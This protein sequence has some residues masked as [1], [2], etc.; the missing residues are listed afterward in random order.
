MHVLL[1]EDEKKTISFLYKGLTENG[2]TV[3]VAEDGPTGLSLACQKNYDIVVLDIM[4]PGCDGWTILEELRSKGRETPVLFL[5]ARDAVDDRVK[6]LEL[7]ADDYLIK[8][9]AFSELLARIR[10]VTRRQ[11][12][13]KP[14]NIKIGDLQVD[15]IRHVVTRKQKLINLTPKEFEL[16]SLLIQ[17]KGEA[18]SRSV[19]AREVWDID[20]DT[21]TNVV[22]VA[23]RRLRSKMDDSFN[24]KLIRTI[25]GVGY[26]FQEP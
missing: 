24:Q 12:Q 16:L 2:V 14:L 23:I 4:L 25:R 22:D 15:F 11:G 17:H 26:V 7:G 18:L 21:G 8:P 19:I 3:E 20:F 13:Q 6:G 5:T 1:V 9:F 10:A